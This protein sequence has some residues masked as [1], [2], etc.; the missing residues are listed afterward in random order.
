[1]IEV[2]G[3]SKPCGLFH[4]HIHDCEIGDDVRIA[5][6]G[7]VV[8]NYV[9][10]SHV[11]VENVSALVADTTA[12]FGNGVELEPVN[13][14]GGRGVTIFNDL[15]AQ[16]AYLQAMLKHDDD[17]SEKMG[18]LI[19][20]HV[21]SQ[22]SGTGRISSGVT[23]LH[24]GE[25]RNVNVGPSAILHRAARLEN[26]TVNS[27]PE[28]PTEVG[29]GVHAESF[30]ISEGAT[31]DGAA[32]ID[33]VFVGQGARIGKQFSAENSLFFANSEG[34]HGEAVA[35]FGG[36]YT[37]TH[38]KSTLLIAGLFSFYNAGSG[39]NQSNHMYKLGPVH[40]GVLERGCKTGSFSYLLH[41]THLGA[42]SVVLGK[43]LVNINIPHL[44]FS[45]IYAEGNDTKM[46][47]AMNIFSIGT[48]RDG[49]KWP[50]RDRR[51]CR[52]LRDLIIF[53]VFSPYT[54]EKMC[55]GR[56][57]LQALSAETSKEKTFINH[58]GV[59]I[60]RLMLRKG[61]KFYSMAIRRY[62]NL[63]VWE[64]LS[65]ALQSGGNWTDAVA[66]LVP[67]TDLDSPAL[68]TDIAGLLTPR[69]RMRSLLDA[70]KAGTISSYQDALAELQRM[71]DQYGSDEWAYVCHLFSR[72]H[73]RSVSE[74]T[75][76]LAGMLLEEWHE[77][78]TSLH[79]MILEDA[80]KEF[81]AQSRI[82]YGLDLTEDEAAAD[83]ESVR[84]TIETN[85]VINK[86][87]A[88]R[89]ALEGQYVEWKT[90]LEKYTK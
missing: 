74:L 2:E 75:C 65:S 76:E 30:V 82:G 29:P 55:S 62:L 54:V 20:A 34:F 73:G 88:E 52:H 8:S 15:T 11:F 58:G 79:A 41:E 70:V 10:E 71:H 85:S 17:F 56:D 47:P 49:E 51:K 25:I 46:I 78:A 33:N 19:D 1:M 45:Y 7:T 48:V 77:M 39:S 26:G 5:S 6:I 61:A 86:L 69:Q 23:I 27:C 60:K 28:H 64:R 21:A 44:P 32:I 18:A 40:Q 24:C 67:A 72:E 81:G 66:S 80:K 63:K 22:T 12:S 16:T 9:I 4:A 68:W 35:V 50:Q 59:Q 14:G 38:H 89:E 90:L 36:P 37:V 57:A 87:N 3:I 83:F 84:G 31:V 43:H 53:E 42:F 13:E